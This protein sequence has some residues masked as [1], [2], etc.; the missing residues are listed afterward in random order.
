MWMFDCRGSVPLTSE[1]FKDQLYC[2]PR[3][4]GL[5]SRVPQPLL[6]ECVATG[7]YHFRKNLCV[8]VLFCATL[9][10]VWFL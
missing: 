10:N 9:A 6:W 8:Y 5:I 3:A 4:K 1:L 7:F 2:P